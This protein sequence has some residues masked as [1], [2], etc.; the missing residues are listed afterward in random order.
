MHTE[1][2]FFF[3]PLLFPPFLHSFLTF[4]HHIGMILLPRISPVRQVSPSIVF[5]CKTL[6]FICKALKILHN[7]SSTDTSAF[8]V[9]LSSLMFFNIGNLP[10][11]YSLKTKYFHVSIS[12]LSYSCLKCH[13]IFYHY[14]LHTNPWIF[15]LSKLQCFFSLWNYLWFYRH[16]ILIP[17]QFPWGD[18]ISL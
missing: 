10:I 4:P 12:C 2:F 17:S 16:N 13:F 1:T 6:K 9:F 14:S 5:I 3:I 8:I 15:L 11:H 18:Y 7:M